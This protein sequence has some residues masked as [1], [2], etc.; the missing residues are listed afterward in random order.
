[1]PYQDDFETLY[2]ARAKGDDPR[3]PDWPYATVAGSGSLAGED[4]CGDTGPYSMIYAAHFAVR[5]A[6]GQS[7]KILPLEAPLLAGRLLRVDPV[8]RTLSLA[9][10]YA[11][12]RNGN[13]RSWGIR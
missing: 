2:R 8:T 9:I 6:S 12:R 1:M 13:E 7:T 5:K 11:Q 3:G 4:L 10:R